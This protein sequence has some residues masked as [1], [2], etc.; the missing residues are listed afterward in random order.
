MP[1]RKRKM[2]ICP[3]C[4][5]PGIIENK[6]KTVCDG[7]GKKTLTKS[8]V[9]GNGNGDAQAYLLKE[10]ESGHGL[11]HISSGLDV[12]EQTMVLWFKRF[13]NGLTYRKVKKRVETYL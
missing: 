5:Q 7:C 6:Y 1:R 3:A 9:M 4:R 8:W 13:F 2:S 12:T 11:Y 10:V